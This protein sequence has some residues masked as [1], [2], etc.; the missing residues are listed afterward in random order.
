MQ[1]CLR[2]SLR[3]TKLIFTILWS[4]LTVTSV[5]Y[6]IRPDLLDYLQYKVINRV[7]NVYTD[8]VALPQITICQWHGSE[9]YH[10][11]VCKFDR[12]HDCSFD[13]ELVD[14]FF[15][16][17]TRIKCIRFNGGKNLTGMKL[18]TLLLVT[19]FYF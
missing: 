3:L 7:E 19:D 15:K 6:M 17:G 10:R 9:S 12:N 1:N 13:Y 5:Y 18:N 11:I 14:V 2:V 4:F 8:S 16:N